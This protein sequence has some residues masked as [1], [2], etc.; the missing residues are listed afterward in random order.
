MVARMWLTVGL[1][2][3]WALSSCRGRDP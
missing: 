1:S 3:S 2:S